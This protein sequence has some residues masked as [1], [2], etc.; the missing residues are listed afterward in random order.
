ME[1]GT[2]GVQAVFS[3]P[4][5]AHAD[6]DSERRQ[7]SALIAA[8]PRS[9]IGHFINSSIS[10]TGD[11]RMMLGWAEGRWSRNYWESKAEGNRPAGVET[12]EWMNVVGYPARPAMIG[13]GGP[14][15]AVAISARV[16]VL[17]LHREAERHL[18]AVFGAQVYRREPLHRLLERAKYSETG[19][20]IGHGA[21]LA[22]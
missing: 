21:S 14:N 4:P 5:A 12:Q 19:R 11:F 17:C 1:C 20:N 10:N 6:P 22:A 8:A 9:G 3:V 15:P 16:A 18:A 7:G 2:G 13:Q